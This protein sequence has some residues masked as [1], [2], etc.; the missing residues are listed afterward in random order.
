MFVEETAT[1]QLG[2][3]RETWWDAEDEG[4][5]GAVEWLAGKL[6]SERRSPG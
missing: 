6:V 4:W 2:I 3:L 1:G 5:V